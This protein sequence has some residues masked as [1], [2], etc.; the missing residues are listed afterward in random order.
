MTPG[1]V[2]FVGGDAGGDVLA[3]LDQGLGRDLSGYAHSLD[4]PGVLDVGLT[5]PRAL[6]AD[7]LGSRD[8]RGNWAERGRSARVELDGHILRVYC[9]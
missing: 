8:L 3:D 5:Q 9:P 4:R 2:Q 7:V 1:P 6:L